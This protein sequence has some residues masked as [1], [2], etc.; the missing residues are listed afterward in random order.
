MQSNCVSV[1]PLETEWG[2]KRQINQSA[3]NKDFSC[4]NGFCPSFV[5]V[6]G[7]KPRKPKPQQDDRLEA[8]MAAL[9][10]PEVEAIDKP[11]N[12]IVTGVGGTGVI[13]IG[14]LL[15]MAAHIEG[16]GASVL[17]FTGLAQKNGAVLSHIRIAPEPDDLH[18]PR[19]ADGSLDLLLGCDL[20]VAASTE[21]MR[22]TERGLTHAIVNDHRMPTAEFTLNPDIE[23]HDQKLKEIVREAAG[24]N[25]TDFVPATEIATALVG[26]S[27]A[28]NVFMMGY[29]YQR[30]TI[31]IQLEAALR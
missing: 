9:P 24:D 29:A 7:G 17:D 22:K 5:T 6:K 30:G 23:F 13:T 12:M 4:L 10:K 19:V 8:Q 16:K 3:C 31:P 11:Y 25:L 28:T 21:A 2:R 26:D 15:G 27:I 20:V 14:Q 18:V 1:E